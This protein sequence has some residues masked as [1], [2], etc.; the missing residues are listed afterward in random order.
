MLQKE[1]QEHLLRDDAEIGSVQVSPFEGVIR[2]GNVRIKDRETADG[3]SHGTLLTVPS[4]VISFD[5]WPWVRSW[6]REYRHLHVVVNNPQVQ[7]ERS[8]TDGALNIRDILS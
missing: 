2:I 4:A 8:K 3:G 5:V 1:I 6:R 7:L